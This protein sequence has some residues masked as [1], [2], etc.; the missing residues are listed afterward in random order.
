VVRQWQGRLHV[1]VNI[2][3]IDVEQKIHLRSHV[4]RVLRGQFHAPRLNQRAHFRVRDV[5]RGVVL[6][7]F[8][9]GGCSIGSFEGDHI[10]GVP[11]APLIKDFLYL[12]FGTAKPHVRRIICNVHNFGLL[13]LN[14][15][16]GPVV[17]QRFSEENAL[18]RRYW[19]L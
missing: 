18:D 15:E 8:A 1:A 3:Q 14:A 17:S 2:F 7:E 12:E 4:G 13:E 16:V 10:F 9:W 5:T 11:A 19:R 6:Q